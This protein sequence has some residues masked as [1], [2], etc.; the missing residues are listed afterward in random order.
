MKLSESTET[1][2][3]GWLCDHGEWIEGWED[4][5][6]R[7]TFPQGTCIKKLGN[8]IKY[9]EQDWLCRSCIAH[10]PDAKKLQY[11]DGNKGNCIYC[12]KDR[13][14]G[15][16]NNSIEFIICTKVA[17]WPSGEAK[18]CGFT[19]RIGSF[20]KIDKNGQPL[21]RGPYCE[22]LMPR[23]D[24]SKQLYFDT[25]WFVPRLKTDATRW[26]HWIC[27]IDWKINRRGAGSGPPPCGGE[28]CKG[29]RGAN[30]IAICLPR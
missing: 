10:S 5:C 7:K 23:R 26:N 24:N 27:N 18:I 4:P 12:S 20:S 17:K 3:P 11:N 28:D 15:P 9:D 30:G 29:I 14:I 16:D 25:A 2:F 19:N 13:A 22:S 21:C 8:S 1:K 6:S